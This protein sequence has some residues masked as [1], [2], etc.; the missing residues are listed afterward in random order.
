MTA[1]AT[2]RVVSH[3]GRDVLQAA[4]SFKTEDAVVWEYVANSIQYVD[5]SVRPAIAVTVSQKQK[6]RIVNNL[7]LF[8]RL[9]PNIS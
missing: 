7:N 4:S 2:L 1:K 5:E 8:I 3:V 6:T 9:S